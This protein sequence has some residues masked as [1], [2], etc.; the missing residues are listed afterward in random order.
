M[1]K[2]FIFCAFIFTFSPLLA[3]YTVK[4]AVYKNHANL[5]K[6]I[7]KI[8][9]TKYRKNIIIEKKRRLYY[10]ISVPYIHKKEVYKALQAYKK[11]FPD[12]FVREV[13]AK[14]IITKPVKIENKVQKPIKSP[15]VPS[16]DAK[17]FL[18]NKTVYLCKEEHSKQNKKEM[19][20]LEFKE[21]Y[22]LYSKRSKNVAPLEIAYIFYKD[23]AILTLS[24]L[25]FKYRFVKEEEG[26][27]LA[28][29]FINEKK[30][31]GFRFYFDE[32]LAHDFN[33]PSLSTQT[34]TQHSGQIQN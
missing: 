15:T 9:V 16:L 29:S 12:A 25:S 3:S 8:P 23:S 18:E 5:M 31:Q 26:F 10:V 13:K 21:N 11:V 19:I 34:K 33:N 4:I 2:I 20:R 22:V 17:Q 24:G 1:K 6:V 7:A 14:N 32:N 28:E 30:G 27:L